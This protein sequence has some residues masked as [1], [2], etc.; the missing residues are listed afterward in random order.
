MNLKKIKRQ[1]NDLKKKKIF[2][3]YIYLNSF[4]SDV[5]QRSNFGKSGLNFPGFLKVCEHFFGLL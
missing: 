4:V 2:F 5:C 3:I 1:F